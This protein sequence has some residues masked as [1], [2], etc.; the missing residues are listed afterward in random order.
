MGLFG[1]RHDD[2]DEMDEWAYELT[3]KDSFPLA[4]TLV[5]A[6]VVLTVAI[7]IILYLPHRDLFATPLCVGTLVALAT[8]GVALLVT[9]RYAAIGWKIGS[10]GILCVTGLIAAAIGVGT[11]IGAMQNDMRAMSE[12]SVDPQGGI[13]LP[14]GGA[15][16]PIS[17]LSFAYFK[18]VSDDVRAH[19]AALHA[20]GYDDLARPDTTLRNHDLLAHCD[21]RATAGPMIEAYYSRREAAV[22]QYRADLQRLDVNETFRKRLVDGID[23][24][25]RQ[26]GDML[27]RAATNEQAQIGELTMLCQILARRHWRDQFGQFGFSSRSDLAEYREHGRRADEL[28]EESNRLMRA[29]IAQV[30]S[31]TAQIRRSLF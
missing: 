21:K 4:A 10:L 11:A 8:W 22:R 7:P 14:P 6:V 30:N 12:I 18:Q 23:E 1:R 2:D 29:S 28:T 26:H 9:L 17:R 15:R 27:R 20:L 19:A 25:Q 13:V 5:G 31:G 24:A 3:R 16:G